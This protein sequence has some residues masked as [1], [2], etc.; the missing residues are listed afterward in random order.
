[1]IKMAKLFE[2]VIFTA[3]TEAYAL[4]LM[5]KLD[6]N[7]ISSAIL[8][9]EFCTQQGAMFVKDMSKLGRKMED[10]IL[11]DNSPNSYYYQPENALPVLN[12]YDN[13][14][15]RELYKYYEFLEAL[16]WV[17]DVRDF[18]PKVN[19]ADNFD[20]QKAKEISTEISKNSQKQQKSKCKFLIFR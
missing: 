18:L 5:Q 1:L 17:P 8:C 10:I 7:R 9:R 16:A 3:S 13:P 15:D 4:P 11:L 19:K 20:Y 12:W 14:M 2:I 6:P